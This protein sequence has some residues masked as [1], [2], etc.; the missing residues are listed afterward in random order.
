MPNLSEFGLLDLRALDKEVML[1]SVLMFPKPEGYL[2][3]SFFPIRGINSNIA[4]WDLILNNYGKARYIVKGSEAKLVAPMPFARK[5]QE[6]AY[7]KEKMFFDSNDIRWRRQPGTENFDTLESEVARHQ[8]ML[9]NRIDVTNEDEMWQCL[10]GT[11]EYELDNGLKISI[12]YGIPEDNKISI[13]VADDKWSNPEAKIISQLRAY[14]KLCKGA[15]PTK[16]IVAPTVMDYLLANTQVQE[17]CKTQ[18]GVQIV[19]EGVLRRIVGLEIVEYN[20]GWTDESGDWFNFLGDREAFILP[21]APGKR[22]VAECSESDWRGQRFLNAWEEKK[23]QHGTWI[24]CGEYS[25]PA[26]MNPYNIVNLSDVA[27][28]GE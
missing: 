12:D 14:K 16:L 3:D 25:L 18:L 11:L 22:L 28:E 15:P 4:I 20:G 7:K 9:S 21:A 23:D 1:E 17:Y 6:V 13:D 27:T 19:E 2:S 26:L 24:L 8:Q 10:R 5:I